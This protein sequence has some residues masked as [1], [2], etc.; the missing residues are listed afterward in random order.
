MEAIDL[1]MKK[2]KEGQRYK[3]IFT[4]FSMPSKDGIEATREI[5]QC[6][7]SKDIP[8]KEQPVIIGVTGHVLDNFKTIGKEAGMDEI[9][10]KPLYLNI[11]I[12]YL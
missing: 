8:R 7:E 1:V 11:L 12:G 9:T 6:L 10:S 3:M 5:R 4:D 2:H